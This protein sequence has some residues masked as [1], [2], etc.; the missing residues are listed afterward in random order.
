MNL[1]VEKRGGKFV[2]LV[3]ALVFVITL[4]KI[5]PQ[6]LCPIKTRFVILYN[7]R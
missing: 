5:N 6:V 3:Y 2:G 7:L 4:S 1:S